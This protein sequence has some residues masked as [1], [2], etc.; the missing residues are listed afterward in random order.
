[1]KQ[2]NKKQFHDALHLSTFLSPLNSNVCY[3]SCTVGGI[4]SI[5]RRTPIASKIG[6]FK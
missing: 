4:N 6:W 1:M 2:V 5:G 3:I